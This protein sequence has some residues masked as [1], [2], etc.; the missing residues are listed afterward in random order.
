M[1]IS[2]FV[3][4]NLSK[5]IIEQGAQIDKVVVKGTEMTLEDFITANNIKTTL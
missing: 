3:A 5:F 4:A 1:I 2:E